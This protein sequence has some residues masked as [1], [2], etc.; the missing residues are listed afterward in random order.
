VAEFESKPPLYFLTLHVE[1]K[2][3][4]APLGDSEFPVF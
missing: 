3:S 2:V 4:G 1:M